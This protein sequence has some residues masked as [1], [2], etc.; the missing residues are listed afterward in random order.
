MNLKSLRLFLTNDN[1]HKMSEF[2][3]EKLELSSFVRPFDTSLK[4]CLRAISIND[5]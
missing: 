3:L 4:V 2:S 1:R 5:I